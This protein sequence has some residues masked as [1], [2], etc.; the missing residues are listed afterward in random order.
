MEGQ[1]TSDSIDDQVEGAGD[2][3]ERTARSTPPIADDAEKGQTETPSEPGDAGVPPDEE[4]GREE[5]PP[6]E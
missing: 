1:P 6:D 4:M 3:G 5:R 2:E